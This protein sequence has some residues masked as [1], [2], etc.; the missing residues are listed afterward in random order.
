M[1]NSYF[2]VRLKVL[3]HILGIPMELGPIYPFR[4]LL[5]G[6]VNTITSFV[7][8]SDLSAMNDNGIVTNSHS[9]INGLKLSKESVTDNELSSLDLKITSNNNKFYLRFYLYFFNYS[10]YHRF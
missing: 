7:L 6:S 2:S 10:C 5:L 1:A 3:N 4:N 8:F 9:L